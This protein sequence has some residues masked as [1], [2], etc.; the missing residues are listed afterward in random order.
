MRCFTRRR[1][2]REGNTSILEKGFGLEISSVKNFATFAA[3][4]ETFLDW[5]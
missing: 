4:R 2:E 1:E 3:S 5:G